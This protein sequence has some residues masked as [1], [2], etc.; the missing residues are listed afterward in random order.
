LPI[1]IVYYRPVLRRPGLLV[2]VF[3]MI[4]AFA[5]CGEDDG[6]TTTPLRLGYFPNV[7]HAP[8]VIG[9]EDG[10][11]ERALGSGVSLETSV[12][13]SGTEAVTA[14]LSG[15]LDA[16]FIGPNPA[17]NAY[18]QSDGEAIRIVAGTASGGAFLVVSPDITGPNDLGGT[19]LAT[20][21]LGNTQDVALRAWLLDQGYETDLEGGGDV[22]VLPQDNAT[23][24]DA[25][26][27][28]SID[29]AWVPEPWATRLVDEGHGK[30]LVD[31]R[32][33]W[34]EG[35]Y[36][37]THLIVATDF[38][39]DHPDVVKALI[40][41]LASAIDLIE[42][43]PERAGDLLAEGIE[44]LTTEPLASTLVDATFANVTFTLDPIASS[45]EESARDAESLDLLDPVDLSGIYDVTLLNEVL[46]E[47]GDP[48]VST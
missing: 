48:E 32:D 17:V 47:R 20:P 19:R 6:A 14:I 23:T 7:T 38:L 16:T 30:I 45:L 10:S 9:V 40:E 27:T 44:T 35:E 42:A 15:A 34:P 33:L 25:F 37:T 1:E 26:V 39:G 2:L 43:D 5:A 8:A 41:G 21:S 22:L 13:G 3:A 28:G 12:F 36:V 18:Q 29:G 4:G 24:L 11:F 31:E 46:T